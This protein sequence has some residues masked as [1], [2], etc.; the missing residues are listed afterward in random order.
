MSTIQANMASH[1]NNEREPESILD[2]DDGPL[3]EES[4]GEPMEG[5]LPVGEEAEED[6]CQYGEAEDEPP[7]KRKKRGK[8]STGN[9]RKVAY[10][11][12]CVTCETMG[13]QW[14]NSQ[15]VCA[16]HERRQLG[17]VYHGA[18]QC[19]LAPGLY[20]KAGRPQF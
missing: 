18:Q 11:G 5:S 2:Y 8:R 7:A 12:R 6:S 9:V 13:H 1:S 14:P 19:D 4:Q 20:K 15:R 16:H 17:R 3:E 10:Q